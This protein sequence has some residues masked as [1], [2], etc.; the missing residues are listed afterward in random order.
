MNAAAAGLDDRLNEVNEWRQ[1][2]TAMATAVHSRWDEIRHGRTA[3]ISARS[4]AAA[5]ETTKV[6][7]IN[8]V[9][10]MFLGSSQGSI[11]DIGSRSFPPGSWRSGR[12]AEDYRRK[13]ERAAIWLF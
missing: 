13:R 9:G 5:T 3:P 6:L 11:T 7:K 10:H 8:R 2:Q 4:T 1:R 12:K